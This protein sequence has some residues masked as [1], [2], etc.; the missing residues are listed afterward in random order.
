DGQNKIRRLCRQAG[1][2]LRPGGSL[3]LEVGDLQANPMVVWLQGLFPS[4]IITSTQDLNGIDRL[5]SVSLP[6]R[7]TCEPIAHG[8]RDTL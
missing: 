3:L 7:A 5:I 6:A 2:K 1:G 8:V 4:A